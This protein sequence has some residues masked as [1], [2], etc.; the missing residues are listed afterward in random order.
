MSSVRAT[1][2]ALRS[3]LAQLPKDVV[4]RLDSD[5]ATVTDLLS[6][7][8]AT[9]CRQQEVVSAA[10]GLRSGL[11]ESLSGL[12]NMVERAIGDKGAQLAQTD[13]PAEPA[14]PPE[15][16]RKVQEL[17]GKPPPKTPDK[18]MNRYMREI[19]SQGWAVEKTGGNHLKV[20]G[21]AGEGPYVFS[22]TPS[23]GTNNRKLRAL[24]EQ[25]RKNKRKDT[26]T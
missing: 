18:D 22:S 19:T 4:G 24:A 15:V 8:L 11:T 10:S 14:M 21:P 7:T 3:V 1:A 6:E 2:A 26:N 16:S 9:S 12:L 25:I 13:A 20:W 23:S 17:R 5:L